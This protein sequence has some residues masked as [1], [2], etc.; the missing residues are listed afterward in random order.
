MNTQRELAHQR[1][2]L[3][4]CIELYALL[5]LALVLLCVINATLV[6]PVMIGG[7]LVCSIIFLHFCTENGAELNITR[8][9]RELANEAKRTDA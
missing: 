9:K 8:L 5:A 3:Y 1:M 4:F 7:G 6:W 2:V